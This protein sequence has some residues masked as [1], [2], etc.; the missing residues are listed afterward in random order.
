MYQAK[1]GS[2]LRIAGC[3]SRNL[4]Y[5][6]GIEREGKRRM[7]PVMKLTRPPADYLAIR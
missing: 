2:G 1:F 3:T 6:Q 4:E 7:K 5:T